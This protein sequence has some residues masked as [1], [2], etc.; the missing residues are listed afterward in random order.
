AG[1]HPYR[2]LRRRNPSSLQRGMRRPIGDLTP[3]NHQSP[4]T[5]PSWSSA[6]PRLGAFFGV[7]HQQRVAR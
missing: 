7:A 6:G 5:S 3:T 4:I 2:F 1:A